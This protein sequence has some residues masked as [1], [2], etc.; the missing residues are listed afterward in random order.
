MLVRGQDDALWHRSWNGSAWSAWVSLGGVL[1]SN[2]N[3]ASCTSGGLDVFVRGQDYSLWRRTLLHLIRE[4][5]K[6]T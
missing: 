6:R 4:Q 5:G 1:Y 3:V 2:P